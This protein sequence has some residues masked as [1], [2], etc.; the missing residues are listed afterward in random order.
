[1]NHLFLWIVLVTIHVAEYNLCFPPF[2]QPV[3][4]CRVNWI[5][6]KRIKNMLVSEQLTSCSSSV[7]E[8]VSDPAEQKCISVSVLT[9]PSPI[10]VFFR[11]VMSR[12]ITYTT[13]LSVRLHSS[14]AQKR[15]P[16]SGTW[17][18]IVNHSFCFNLF[19]VQN[20]LSLLSLVVY[21]PVF[22]KD[23]MKCRVRYQSPVGRELLPYFSASPPARTG[24]AR[25]FVIFKMMRLRMLQLIYTSHGYMMWA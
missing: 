10:K 15:E 2:V 7:W 11:C 4:A 18:F 6:K 17:Q 14:G 1:M 20:L 8:G 5:N 22:I 16:C 12:P 13:V 24:T 23:G 19:I 21:W 9:N 25:S 3:W